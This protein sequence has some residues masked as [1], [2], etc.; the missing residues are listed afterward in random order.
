MKTIKLDF[1]AYMQSNSA[2]EGFS[3]FKRRVSPKV[4]YRWLLS[5]LGEL[6]GSFRFCL[7]WLCFDE[8]LL[9]D[10]NEKDIGP[11]IAAYVAFE[12]TLSR[13][14]YSDDG[15]IPELRAIVQE[16][17]EPFTVWAYGPEPRFG[18]GAVAETKGRPSYFEKATNCRW[19][20]DIVRMFSQAYNVEPDEMIVGKPGAYLGNYRNRII[21]RPKNALKHR[22]ISAEP[23]WLGWLQQGLKAAIY[24]YVESHPQILTWFSNQERS[25]QLALRGSIDGSYATIDFSDASDSVTRELVAK[26]YEH[27]YFVDLLLA[28]RSTH[29]LLPDGRTIALSKFA[30]MG[31]ATCFC[32]MDVLLC[33]CCELAIRD[34]LGRKARYGDYVVYGDDVIIRAAAVPRFLQVVSSLGMSVNSDKSYWD[35]T[36]GAFYRESCGIEAFNGVDVTPTRY[37]RFQE[38]VWCEDVPS[39][40]PWLASVVALCNNLFEAGYW[41]A[42]SAVIQLLN[43]A[44]DRALRL[45]TDNPTRSNTER[46]NRAAK[47][48]RVWY[49]LLRVDASDYARGWNGPLVVVVPDGTA[50]NYH[51][52][53]RWNARL[54]R[55]EHLVSDFTEEM[56]ETYKVPGY[57]D[58]PEFYGLWFHRAR[59]E[60]PLAERT[61][62]VMH[63]AAGAER[64]RWRSVWV[65]P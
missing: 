54:Q 11:E 26:V 56:V 41:S 19:E 24:E 51:C 6:W 30:P 38:P 9:L 34:T 55:R 1:I 22:I 16:W 32:T 42:R 35:T 7:E 8:R 27:T 59:S 14:E 15:P 36:S 43:G 49:H 47:V 45:A 63:G 61:Q 37:S 57:W 60:R 39:D 28:A 48:R 33:A 2:C 40:G 25:R 31:S 52:K 10:T 17:F 53:S 50:S 5:V 18:P 46:A 44:L 4:T 58:N 20:P 29:A 13:R 23:T 65:C 62:S 64:Q 3:G 21:F 12:D